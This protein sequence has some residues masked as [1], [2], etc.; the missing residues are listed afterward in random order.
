V[1]RRFDAA[2]ARY[3]RSWIGDLVAEL[4]ALDFV[5]W[6]TIFGAELL[7]SALPFIILLSSLANE[8]IDDDLSRHIGLN[9]QGSRIVAGLFRGTPAHDVFAIATGLIFT[10]SGLI[11]VVGSLQVIYERTHD[12]EHRGWQNL[13]RQVGWVAVLLAALVAQGSFERPLRSSVGPVLQAL[14]SLALVTIFFAWTIHFLLS[15]RVPWRRVVEPALIT[16]ILWIGLALVSSMYFSSAIVSDKRT[17]GTIGVAFTLLTWFFAIGAVV[18]LGA[19]GG[20][21][22]QRRVE[23]GPRVRTERPDRDTEA[24]TPTLPGD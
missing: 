3:E 16:S 24:R 6:M 21:V 7:W 13:P 15:G 9:A 19:A 8:R 10:A 18:I 17:Y 23:R 4:K 14:L 20:A 5:N 1:R 12:L 11:A 22:W 2:R